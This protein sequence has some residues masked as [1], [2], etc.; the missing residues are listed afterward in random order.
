MTQI[1]EI[2]EDQ[3]QGEDPSGNQNRSRQYL[4]YYLLKR[5]LNWDYVILRLSFIE[6]WNFYLRNL[7]MFVID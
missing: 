2:V 4:R 3:A 6:F 5:I 1:S 7:P